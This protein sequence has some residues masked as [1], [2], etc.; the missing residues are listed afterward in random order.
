MAVYELLYFWFRRRRRL[1]THVD[2]FVMNDD[3]FRRHYRLSKNIVRW[4]CDELRNDAALRRQRCP[5][6]VMTVE[7]QVLCALRF[8]ATGSY[9]GQVASDRHL[10]VRQT[11]VSACVR[12]VSTA[13][14]RRLGPRWIAFPQTAEER[15]AAQEAFLRRG[16][17][18]GVVGCGDGTFV[19]MKGPSKDDPTVTKALYRCVK[20]YYALNV[21]VVSAIYFTVR[22][23]PRLT[24]SEY[25]IVFTPIELGLV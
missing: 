8:Y 3:E 2:A 5:R 21:M 23:H 12:A 15:A 7:Q 24:R 17:L 25:E 9:Q 20:L 22:A 14:V 10:A 4:L 18:P 19:A 13:I 11:T 16:S 1:F 6:T